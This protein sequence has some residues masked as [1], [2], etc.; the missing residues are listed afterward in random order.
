MKNAKIYRRSGVENTSFDIP[1]VLSGFFLVNFSKFSCDRRRHWAREDFFRSPTSCMRL[2]SKRETKKARPK[3]R[4]F[5]RKTTPS[6]FFG[7]IDTHIKVSLLRGIPK[8]LWTWAMNMRNCTTAR[9]RNAKRYITY[10]LVDMRQLKC[11]Y[12]AQ[13]IRTSNFGDLC[14]PLTQGSSSHFWRVWRVR[15]GDCEKSKIYL[16]SSKSCSVKPRKCPG[17]RSETF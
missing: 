11:W 8:T 16:T 14:T 9:Y 5:L 7:F 10:E 6:K 2:A 4:I 12:S 1:L 3:Q 17:G 15:P 13:K